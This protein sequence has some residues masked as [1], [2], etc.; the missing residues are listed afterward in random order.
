M[1][2]FI[3]QVSSLDDQGNIIGDSNLVVLEP[4]AWVVKPFPIQ[5]YVEYSSQLA[6]SA[7]S[8]DTH[9]PLQAILVANQHFNP[10]ARA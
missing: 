7:T 9:S 2:I 5:N 10:F 4:N 3:F 6:Y 8:H 1:P